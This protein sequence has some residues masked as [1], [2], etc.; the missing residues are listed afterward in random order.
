MTE[1]FKD[2]AMN[3]VVIKFFALSSVSVVT[4]RHTHGRCIASFEFLTFAGGY[5]C[6][7]EVNN[8]V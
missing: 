5:F 4:H 7:L 6:S 1:T 2:A 8:F 3:V